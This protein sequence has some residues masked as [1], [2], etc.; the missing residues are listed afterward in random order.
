MG[1][2]LHLLPCWVITKGSTLYDTGP[3]FYDY[4]YF[5]TFLKGENDQIL[6]IPDLTHVDF[7]ERT[8]V[9]SKGEEVYFRISGF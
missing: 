9:T 7:Y 5:K 4:S 8:I 6:V 2:P 1:K 3:Y